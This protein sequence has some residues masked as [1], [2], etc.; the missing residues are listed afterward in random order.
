M[1]K[2]KSVFTARQKKV[3]PF[4]VRYK[5]KMEWRENSIGNA[6]PWQTNAPGAGDWIWLESFPRAP[7]SRTCCNS[8]HLAGSSSKRHCRTPKIH[9][10]RSGSVHS[11]ISDNIP[12]L[13]FETTTNGVGEN[14]CKDLRSF[15]MMTVDLRSR[16]G[17]VFSMYTTA[18]RG[19]CQAT[20]GSMAWAQDLFS[21]LEM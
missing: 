4:I 1:A 6:A 10:E 15:F 20:S 21:T 7:F 9:S 18:R 13:T 8:I 14:G 17:R 5:S 19:T 3:N 12:L 11:L 16:I 2:N